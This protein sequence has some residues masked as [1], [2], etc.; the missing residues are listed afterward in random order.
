M[1]QA[2]CLCAFCNRSERK[3]SERAPIKAARP[4]PPVLQNILRSP[5]T[6]A[7]FS[8]ELGRAAEKA[9]SHF[10]APTI[11][12]N[13]EQPI[14]K[15]PPSK[16]HI[17]SFS[18]LKTRL[19]YRAKGAEEISPGQRPGYRGQAMLFALKGRWGTLRPFRA[20]YKRDVVC[21]RGH[22]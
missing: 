11:S 13:H 14:H 12:G 6:Q 22:I 20:H 15:F 17:A 1:A 10:V 2:L 16:M 8:R 9:R 7:D 5:T 21:G 19:R 18:R 4:K 3:L